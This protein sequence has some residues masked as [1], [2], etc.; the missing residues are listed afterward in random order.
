MRKEFDE[1]E[2]T[3]GYWQNEFL[4]CGWDIINIDTGE[5]DEEKFDDLCNTWR[6]SQVKCVFKRTYIALGLYIKRCNDIE[7]LFKPELK[8]INQEKIKDLMD[9]IQADKKK[10][11]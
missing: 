8:G 6:P 10:K 4:W 11:Q 3:D 9:K 7:K 2:W 5:F 1:S